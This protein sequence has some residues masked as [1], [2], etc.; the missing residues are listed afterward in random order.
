V[1]SS[2]TDDGL[3]LAE[4]IT[5]HKRINKMANMSYCRFENTLADLKDC[6][7]HINDELDEEVNPEEVYARETLISL[8]KRITEEVGE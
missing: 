6:Y 8:C 3:T 4:T 7:E 2:T 5:Q 1:H